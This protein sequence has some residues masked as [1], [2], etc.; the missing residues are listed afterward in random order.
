MLAPTVRLRVAC[1]VTSQKRSVQLARPVS[2]WHQP[3]LQGDPRMLVGHAL[4]DRF[5]N[6]AGMLADVIPGDQMIS[7][8]G[9]HDWTS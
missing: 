8:P 2:G 1:C 3:W 5:A 9:G 6:T 7:I 4:D